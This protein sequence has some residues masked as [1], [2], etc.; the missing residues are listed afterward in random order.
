MNP[1]FV[2]LVL[3]GGF[4]IWA[5]CSSM[6][7]TIGWWVKSIINNIKFATRQDSFDKEDADNE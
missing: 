3:I 6:F 4:L 5:L 1:I 7:K 2:F